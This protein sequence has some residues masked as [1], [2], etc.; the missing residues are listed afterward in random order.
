MNNKNIQQPDDRTGAAALLA[1]LAPDEGYNLSPLPDVR[2]LRSNR[3]LASTPVLYDPGIVIVCQ[4]RK[5]GFFGDEVYLY[6]AS[7]YLAVSVPVPF[8]METD[9]SPA[10]PLLAIYLHLDFR[11]AADLMLE[12]DRHGGPP[13]SAPRGMFSTAMDDRMAASV[14]RFL[15]AMAAPMEA[16]ILGPALLRELYFH[17]LAGE[18]GHSMRAALAMQ[19]QFG[20]I[21]RALRRIHA[22]YRQA[23]DVE[24][25][26]GESG[27]SVPSFHTHFRSVTQTSPMQ[28]LK[29]TRLHQARLLMVRNGVTAAAASNEVGYESP[30]QFSREFKRLF[31]RSPMEE[32]RRMKAEFA[33]P[34]PHVGSP[35][36]SSH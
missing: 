19:G 23:L 10:E 16:A 3:P 27:M 17:V 13:P 34:P 28:Y 30:S 12:I 4:G 36:V 5:R 25:L 6:D 9:A 11:L 2:F 24:S 26:A 33:L 15:A 8:T 21:A 32:A 35:F 14:L 31:G 20:K 18:Q 7:H 22:A 29:S 1:R